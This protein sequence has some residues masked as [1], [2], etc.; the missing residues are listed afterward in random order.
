M[1]V[2]KKSHR[3]LELMPSKKD[4]D[5]EEDTKASTPRSNKLSKGGH[6]SDTED[7]ESH[8]EQCTKKRMDARPIG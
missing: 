7:I 2:N 5:S 1:D 3:I 6:V 8:M 4:G